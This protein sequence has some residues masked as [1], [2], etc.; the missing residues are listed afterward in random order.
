MNRPDLWQSVISMKNAHLYN[1]LQV[2]VPVPGDSPVK[3]FPSTICNELS[4]IVIFYGS[5]FEHSLL[6]LGGTHWHHLYFDI[7]IIQEGLL[8]ML[9][10]Y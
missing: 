10:R 6:L 2:E 3:T 9:S 1:Y 4:N 5:D 8:P 7:S